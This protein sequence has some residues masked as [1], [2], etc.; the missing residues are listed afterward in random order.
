MGQTGSHEVLATVE[1][2][3]GGASPNAKVLVKRLVVHSLS[4]RSTAAHEI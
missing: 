2:V 4:P 1:H 3:G